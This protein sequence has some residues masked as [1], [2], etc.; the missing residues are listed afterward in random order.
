VA[1][2]GTAGARDQEVLSAP[3]LVWFRQD[4]RLADNP[5]LRSA[6]ARGPVI[7]VYIWS[8]EEEGGW[9]PG[10][11][12]RWWLH[13]SLHALDAELR[14][15]RSR[16]VVRRGPALAV[17]RRL[18]AETGADAVRWNRRYEP[19]AVERDAEAKLALADDGVGV[20][21]FNAALLYEPWTIATGG[22]DPYQVFTPF[23]RACLASAPPPEPEPAPSLSA[24]PSWPESLAID[25]LGLEPEVDWAGGLERTWTPGEHAAGERLDAFLEGAVARYARDRD[26]P[27]REGTS[28][29]SPHLH[30]GEIGPRQ[31]WHEIRGRGLDARR[32]LAEVGWREFAHH[33]LYHFPH[34]PEHP[35]RQEFERLSWRTDR[36]AL[37]AWQR[38]ETGYPLVDA[39]MHQLW[40]TGWMHN[41]VRM[42][43]ASFLVK[44]LLLPWQEGARWFWD[45]LVDADLANNTLG[46]QWTA[47][48]GA[49]A[50]PFFRVFNPRLQADRYDSRGDYVRTWAPDPP[51]P[52]VDHREARKR[53][54]E[55]YGDV[56]SG[57][58]RR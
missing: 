55:A 48:C 33:L 53:A 6:A 16:L 7:P 12:S 49:D 39:G 13:R 41:R 32:F 58:R 57:S 11:A 10:G 35:L 1:G 4:L 36:P 27:D 40:E 29:L 25:E 18:V 46:W 26:R 38:G 2:P 20:E 30:H 19:Y 42:V 14:R 45:T 50:A 5:A 9:E 51:G 54:L 37:R 34:T 17:L 21:S 8:P 28:R 15:H 52:I 3:A 56:R 31:I 24:P 43:A 47:G 44:D 22:G 23:W